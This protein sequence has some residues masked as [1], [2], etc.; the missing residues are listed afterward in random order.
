MEQLRGEA[1]KFHKPGETVDF[2]IIGSFLEFE[3]NHS[4]VCTVLY[5]AP[6]GENWLK[7][8]HVVYCSL[9]LGENYTTEGYVVTPNTMILLKKHLEETGGQV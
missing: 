5:N 9:F 8:Y 3:Q 4:T 1:L 6:S 2:L 7:V